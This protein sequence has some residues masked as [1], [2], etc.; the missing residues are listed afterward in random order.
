VHDERA[1]VRLTLLL[2]FTV[3]D[4]ADGWRVAVGLSTALGLLR[5]EVEPYSARLA[6]ADRPSESVPI[7]CMADG[8][9]GAF[10]AYPV[11]H[12]GWHAETGVDGMR[13]GEGEQ[14]GTRG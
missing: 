9:H 11:G 2:D 12:D 6:A 10:C 13:W 14:S 8:P 7:F 5:P 3:D 1:Q 4:V